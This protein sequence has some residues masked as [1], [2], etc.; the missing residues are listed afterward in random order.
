MHLL[1][2]G[3]F[4]VL[5]AVVVFARAGSHATPVTFSHGFAAATGVAAML[6]LAGA[7]AGLFL[8]GICRQ[9]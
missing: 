7:G 3:E 5:L 1:A 8:P 4:W 9:R 6:S 2:D